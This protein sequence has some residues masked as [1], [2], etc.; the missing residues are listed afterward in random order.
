LR[1][2]I[3]AKVGRREPSLLKFLIETNVIIP[4]EPPSAHDDL[5]ATNKRR[6][7]AVLARAA[8]ALVNEK[9]GTG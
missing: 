8:D 4:L 7:D 6:S 3:A 5:I 9:E 2:Q 1:G